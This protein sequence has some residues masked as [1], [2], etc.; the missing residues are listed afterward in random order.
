MKKCVFG[1]QTNGMEWEPRNSSL[2]VVYD[3]NMYGVGKPDLSD[4][5]AI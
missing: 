4:C 2:N 5:T 1:T 3:K